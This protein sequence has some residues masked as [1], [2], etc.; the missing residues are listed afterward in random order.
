MC[1]NIVTL[2]FR[3]VTNKMILIVI[4]LF[5]LAL[6]AGLAYWKFSWLVGWSCACRVLTL[7]W[8]PLTLAW[9]LVT[10]PYHVTLSWCLVALSYLVTLW[11]LA[12]VCLDT[13]H[14]VWWPCYSI[15]TSSGHP[16][17]HLII[18]LSPNDLMLFSESVRLS[19][20]EDIHSTQ[21]VRQAVHISTESL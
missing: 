18:Y 20:R 8:C 2:F 16:V 7:L 17:P 19:V 14:E 13:W 9:Y 4:I 6:L 11:Y 3:V 5:E 12:T 10:W 1:K 15:W 21:A